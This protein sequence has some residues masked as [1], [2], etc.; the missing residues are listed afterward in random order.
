MVRDLDASTE[1]SPSK[2]EGTSQTGVFD[3]AAIAVHNPFI[4]IPGLTSCMRW[5][6]L[7]A[8]ASCRSVA[9]GVQV[10]LRGKLLGFNS[11][12]ATLRL[13]VPGVC[14]Q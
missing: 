12:E 11:H 3:V 7:H 10:L 8:R 9:L 6:G 14:H 5:V 4:S 2:K 1:T 13:S